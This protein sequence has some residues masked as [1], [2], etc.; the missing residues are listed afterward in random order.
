MLTARSAT[1][2]LVDSVRKRDEG[3]KMQ[4]GDRVWFYGLDRDISSSITSIPT[5]SNDI[6]RSDKTEEL[7]FHKFIGANEFN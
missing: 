7:S 4:L 2:S 6:R 3:T 1:G 5:N